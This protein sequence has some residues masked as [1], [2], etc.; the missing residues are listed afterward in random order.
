MMIELT[1]ILFGGVEDSLGGICPELSGRTLPTAIGR[2]NSTVVVVIV[3]V[4]DV[5]NDNNDVNDD[6]NDETDDDNADDDDELE[7]VTTSIEDDL[8]SV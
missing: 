2:I 3:F 8:L 4:V 6:N 5:D 7:V 1:M